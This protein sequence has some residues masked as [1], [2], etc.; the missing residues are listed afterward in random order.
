[1]LPIGFWKGSGF[2]LLTDMMIADIKDSVRT[3]GVCEIRY[4][5][6]RENRVRGENLELR[7]PVNEKIWDAVKAL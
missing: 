1:V 5:G 6:E 2:S 3:E 7:I 4:P